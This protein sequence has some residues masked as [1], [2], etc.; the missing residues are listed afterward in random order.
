MSGE[1]YPKN[2]DEIRE[3]VRQKHNYRCACCH[4]T[5]T[6]L[7]IHHIVPVR[8]GGSHRRTN[9]T[10]L[11]PDCH[12]AVHNQ[13]MA[14]VVRWYTNNNLT[15]DEFSAHKRFWKQLREKYGSP[16]YHPEGEYIYTP[17]AD[18][19]KIVK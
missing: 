6:P 13:E 16:R 7:E 4:R 12:S 9:L 2:W 10:P 18:V 15:Q 3:D 1:N 8:L 5:E 11:C 19:E 17:L 14:P